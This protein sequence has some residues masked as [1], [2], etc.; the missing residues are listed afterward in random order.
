MHY[1]FGYGSLICADSRSRTGITDAAFPIEVKGIARHW[2]LHTPAWQATV[3]SAHIERN[4]HCNGVY[5]QVD[6]FNL[7]LFDE[8]ESGYD[9]IELDWR[10]VTALSADPLPE[11]GKLWVYVGHQIGKPSAE[12]P[13]MQSYLDVIMNG[14][15]DIHPQF[16]QRFTE[17]TGQ[18][19]H[20]V[21]DRENPE[22]LRPLKSSQRHGHID[23]LLQSHLPELWHHRSHNRQR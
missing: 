11:D 6:D 8:R 19:E 12:R 2:S 13:I 10:D 7:S 15:L 17:L 18:W 20:L 14:C 5:F 1:I 22:Y 4:A 21:N 16:A 23:Q 3:V 9:R